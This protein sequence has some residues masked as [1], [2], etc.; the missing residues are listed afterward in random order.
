M[1]KDGK[2]NTDLYTPLPILQR[3]WV[4]LSMDFVLG[5]PRTIRGNDSI[6]VVV[7]RFS[8]MAHFV[9]YR[10]TFDAYHIASLFL[11]EIMHLHGIPVSIIFDR[12]VKF[13]SYFWKNL[14][15]KLGTRL[16]FYSAFYP[17][18]DGQ[19]KVTNRSLGNL[20]RCLINEHDASWDLILPQTEFAYN[21]SANQTI[22]TTP[23]ELVYGLKPKIPTDV[24]PLPLPQ[25][26]SEAGV[27]FAAFMLNL[28]E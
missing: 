15:A 21:N 16:L 24:T 19:T 20:L 27:D 12:D 7:D 25:K 13:V 5:L 3:P 1:N 10:K 8:K 28:H 11:R 26:V 14:W 22:G 9:P 6:M 2:H 4:D 17:Q 18:T 23:F